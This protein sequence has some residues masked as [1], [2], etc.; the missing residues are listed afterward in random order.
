MIVHESVN[1]DLAIY[2]F[3]AL[4]LIFKYKRAIFHPCLNHTLQTPCHDLGMAVHD[5]GS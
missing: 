1:Y 2:N 5:V 4:E 3:H